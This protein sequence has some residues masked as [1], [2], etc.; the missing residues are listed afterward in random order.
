MIGVVIILGQDMIG[1]FLSLN[2][3]LGHLPTPIIAASMLAQPVLTAL[4]AVLLLGQ[5]LGLV[6]V[7][8][9]V[10]VMMGIIIVHRS[11]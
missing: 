1:G 5:L 6:Q 8:G 11:R 9:G 10:M 4:F 2:Y 3:A 7:V